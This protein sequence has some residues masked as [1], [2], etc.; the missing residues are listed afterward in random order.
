MEV[1]RTAE[2]L[3]LLAALEQ[4][5]TAAELARRLALP[6]R[7]LS[8]TLDVL[9][10]VGYVERLGAMFEQAERQPADL[11]MSALQMAVR[12]RQPLRGMIHHSDRGVQY[13]SRE[14]RAFLRRHGIERSMRRKG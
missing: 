5:N 3:G 13:A 9:R 8:L 2:L 4:P 7:T 1:V 12:H 11:A 14:Y 6:E 10:A